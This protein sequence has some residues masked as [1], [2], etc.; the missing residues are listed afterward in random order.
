MSGKSR[1]KGWF[2]L[3]AVAVGVL[4][5]MGLTRGPSRDVRPPADSPP[6]DSSV[7]TEGCPEGMVRIGRAGGGFC[8]DRY[9]YPNRAGEEPVRGV[10]PSY[11][12]R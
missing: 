9:E 5:L 12:R 7:W 1:L 4:V 2:W 6:P 11:A 3:I 10:A 8:I